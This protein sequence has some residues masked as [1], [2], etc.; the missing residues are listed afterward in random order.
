MKKWTCY[1]MHMNYDIQKN[2]WQPWQ[3]KHLGNSNDLESLEEGKTRF[4]T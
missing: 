1:T 2:F 4:F 3:I